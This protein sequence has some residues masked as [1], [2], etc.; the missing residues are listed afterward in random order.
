MKTNYLKCLLAA[1]LAVAGF[2]TARAED[3]KAGGLCYNIISEDEKTV[4]VTYYYT[5]YNDYNGYDSDKL[6]EEGLTGYKGSSGIPEKVSYGG[7]EYTVVA[8]GGCAF[9]NCYDLKSMTIPVSV[10]LIGGMAFGG[11]SSLTSVKMPSVKSIADFAF[12]GCTSLSSVEMPS[13]TKIG[14]SAF[15][16]CTSLASIDISAFTESIDAF[17]FYGCTNLKE[18]NVDESNDIYTSVDG[19]L[20]N[21]DVTELILCP[22]GITSLEVPN[23]VISINKSAF[24]SGAL[25]SISMPSVTSIGYGAFSGFTSLSSVEMP[26]VTEIE[27]YAFDGCASLSSIDI[28]ASVTSIGNYA[29]NC[30]NLTSVYCHWQAP[31]ELEFYFGLFCNY[32]AT[33]YVPIGTRSAYEAVSPWNMFLNIVEMNYSS[34]NETKVTAP[35][36]TVIDGAIVI[37]DERGAAQAV[38]VYSTGGECVHRGTGTRIEG[39]PHGVYV[40]RVGRTATKV[41]L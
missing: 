15:S 29:F 33:L 2:M 5:D 11:C 37:G 35:A 38:E 27:R 36:V 21:K 28:P 32:N 31:L 14:R 4:E 13:V 25:R 41:V 12:D 20:Y 23:T 8:I 22:A 19:V 40:V 39:L 9:S 10:T 7:T 18:I 17:A 26:S 6:D 24:D 1:L 3:F 30:E 34:I 16:G